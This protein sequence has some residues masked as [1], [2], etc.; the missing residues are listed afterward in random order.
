[1]SKLN[2]KIVQFISVCFSSSNEHLIKRLFEHIENGTL[3]NDFIT[4][5]SNLKLP[6]DL[7]FLAYDM[8]NQAKED[9]ISVANL[10]SFIDLA[11]IMAKHQKENE[12]RISPVWT[13]PILET[14]VVKLNTYDTVKY[15]IESAE[16]EIF[17]VGYTF[18]FKEESVRELLKS[19]ER[20]V[21][22]NCR[23]NII[24]NDVENNFKEIM[25]NWKKASYQLNVYH[26]VGSS[27]SD[28]TSLHAKLIIADQRKVLL[29]SANFSYH[30]FHKNIETGVL[31][32]NPKF[33]RDIWKQY[34]SLIKENHM[35]KA[36]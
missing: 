2:E 34:H 25:N 6:F 8:L 22:R 5:Q 17:I 32:D 36:Y 16:Q 33:S 23:V 3:T 15:L 30:G 1:M 14:G 28:Y 31:V 9:D 18:S 21:E 13:G 27:L 11:F 19:I 12:P 20:S 4:W 35:K 26:W 10:K 7:E 24:V 29:T